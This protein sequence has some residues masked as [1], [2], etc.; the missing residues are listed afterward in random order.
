M[1]TK[2]TKVMGKFSSVTVSTIDEEEDEIEA[3]SCDVAVFFGFVVV[4]RVCVTWKRPKRW[5]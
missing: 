4:I 2:H 1:M 5:L 3:V